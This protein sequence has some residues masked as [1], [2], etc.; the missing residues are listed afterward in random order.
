MGLL[1]GVTGNPPRIYKGVS[2]LMTAL[3]EEWEKNFDRPISRGTELWSHYFTMNDRYPTLEGVEKIQRPKY[4]EGKRFD[5]TSFR[6]TKLNPNGRL[7]GETES[8]GGL[9]GED[10]HAL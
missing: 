7:E 8:K 9:I 10:K 5:P 3:H 2:Y 4:P 1:G 6:G